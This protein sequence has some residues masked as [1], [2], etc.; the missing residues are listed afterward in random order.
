MQT[1]TTETSVREVVPE[2]GQGVFWAL[3]FGSLEEARHAVD[4]IQRLLDGPLGAAFQRG[5]LAAQVLRDAS[6]WQPV[7]YFS[8]GARAAAR[9]A[10]VGLP[11]HDGTIRADASRHATLLVSARPAGDPELGALGSIAKLRVLVVEDQLDTATM[12]AALLTTWGFEAEVAHSGADAL[13]VAAEFRPRVVLLDLGLPDQHGY[14]LARRMREESTSE[15]SFVV[16]TGWS[17]RV[18]QE[19]SAAAGISHHLVKPVNPDALHSILTRYADTLK[20]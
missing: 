20:S 6:D 18:D 15:M 9:M 19:L 14:R 2:T 13:R 12:L 3:R 11:D 8:A 16:V 1:G 7:L 5:N 17:Q 10:G 4:A